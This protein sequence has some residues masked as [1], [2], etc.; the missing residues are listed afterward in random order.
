MTHDFTHDF[1]HD[2][3]LLT[4]DTRHTT[5]RDT[6]PLAITV[7]NHSHL[8][9]KEIYYIPSQGFELGIELGFELRFELGIE[10]GIRA[11]NSS[12][13]FKLGIGL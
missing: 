13:E 5:Y 7:D 11:R 4:H 8:Q 9:N 12:S 2:T 6:P 10:L 1:T 3:R